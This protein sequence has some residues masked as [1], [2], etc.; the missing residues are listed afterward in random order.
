YVYHVWS[1]IELLLICMY[2]NSKIEE[3]NKRKIGILIATIGVA[4]GIIN[5]CF[6]QPP[7]TINSI[8][9]LYE[10]FAIIGL[11]LFAFYDLAR[12]EV[13]VLNNVH[14]WITTIL[15]VYWSVVFVY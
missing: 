4:L 10:G 2:F 8:F 11:G 13:E 14:F 1:P 9:L 7:N 5:A 3:L 6:L 12:R 15:M